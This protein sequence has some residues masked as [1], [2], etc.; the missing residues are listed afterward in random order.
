MDSTT[1]GLCV[2]VCV[3]VCSRPRLS[4]SGGSVSRMSQLQSRFTGSRAAPQH[5][6]YVISP[7]QNQLSSLAAAAAA[8]SSAAEPPSVVVRPSTVLP[9]PPARPVEPTHFHWNTSSRR[10]RQ[11]N[12]Q[13]SDGTTSDFKPRLN[14]TVRHSL[15]S[16]SST[17]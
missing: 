6:S 16:A 14:C 3:C 9:L 13:P 2:C 11:L 10:K 8:A 12:Q 17:V 15:I 1:T 4:S 7:Y 5:D